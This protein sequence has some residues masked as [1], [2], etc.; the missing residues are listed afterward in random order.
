MSDRSPAAVDSWTAT[1]SARER[2]RAV[3]DTLSEP[4]STNWISEQAEAAWSTANDE[5]QDLV[6]QGRLRRIEAGES[7]LYQPDY[8]RL[9]FEEIRTLIEDHS[10]EE[11]RGELT[12]IAEEIEEWQSSYGVETWKELEGSL[13]DSELSSAEIR[14]RREVIAFWQETEGDRQL[15]K[16][17]LELYSDVESAREQMTSAV[18]RATS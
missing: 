6:S 8:T 3:A 9:L 17:A 18:D 7:T 13:A 11:L 14:D 2:V 1:M 16:H 15:L 5:L 4:R 10:R 12:A